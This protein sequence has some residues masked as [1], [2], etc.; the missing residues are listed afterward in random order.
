MSAKNKSFNV[1]AAA[2]SGT[3]DTVKEWALRRATDGTT[4]RAGPLRERRD[5]QKRKRAVSVVAGSVDATTME[6]VAMDSATSKIAA[7]VLETETTVPRMAKGE[8][9]GVSGK[10]S[11]GTE[12]SIEV[13]RKNP[14]GWMTL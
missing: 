10:G 13:K 12:T 6:S 11:A 14:N 8:A 9:V 2:F 1:V 3:R 5:R 4:E 7:G